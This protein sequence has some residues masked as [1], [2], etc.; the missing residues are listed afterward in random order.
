MLHSFQIPS[1]GKLASICEPSRLSKRTK[2]ASDVAQEAHPFPFILFSSLS[3]F[4]FSLPSSRSLFS[5]F[6]H[7]QQ[8]LVFLSSVQP[9]SDS[10]SDMEGVGGGDAATASGTTAAAAAPGKG[11]ILDA[12]KKEKEKEKEGEEK[13]K[14]GVD[15]DLTTSSSPPHSHQNSSP[16]PT[17]R[18]RRPAPPR[19]G[20]W[21]PS[22]VSRSARRASRCSSIS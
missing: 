19:G 2:C 14:E 16:S 12:G 7:S 8:A 20:S 22:S 17:G 10:D 1:L 9:F 5:L 21:P 6:L 15:S 3:F 13:G 4:F 18:T 11:S